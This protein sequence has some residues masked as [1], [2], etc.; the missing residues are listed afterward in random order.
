MKEETKEKIRAYYKNEPKDKKETR[1]QKIKEAHA[2]RKTA[3]QFYLAEMKKKE[4]LEQRRKQYKEVFEMLK[5][6]G[7][8]IVKDNGETINLDLQ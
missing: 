5:S 6:K 8:R 2:L 3:M 7:Y 1:I 4:E